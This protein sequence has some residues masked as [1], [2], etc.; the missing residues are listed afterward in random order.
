MWYFKLFS[1]R[2]DGLC[3]ILIFKPRSSC[4]DTFCAPPPQK[5]C[6]LVLSRCFDSIYC[7]NLWRVATPCLWDSLLSLCADWAASITLP[8]GQSV[9]KDEVRNW[10]RDGVGCV[11]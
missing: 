2:N 7:Y 3:R 6:L 9:S 1:F 8:M 5:M 10:C 4:H 11:I